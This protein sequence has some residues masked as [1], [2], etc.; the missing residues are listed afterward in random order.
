MARS[1]EN[2][3][4]MGKIVCG[5]VNRTN[6][7]VT[8]DI[9]LCPLALSPR[10]VRLGFGS[11]LGAGGNE[12]ELP[13]T[14]GLAAV[15]I[16][17]LS[18]FGASVAHAGTYPPPPDDLVILLPVDES[19]EAFYIAP[20]EAF[21]ITLCCFE[22]G[23]YVEFSIEAGTTGLGAQALVSSGPLLVAADG[24]VEWT[25]PGLPAGNYSLLVTVD[26]VTFSVPLPVGQIIPQA[27]S[28]PMSMLQP[29]AVLVAAGVVAMLVSYRRRP[30][31]VI[32]I[33]DSV[34]ASA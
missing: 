17:A 11:H 19:G 31:P 27:G 18:L 3:V 5:W 33:D 23:T 32:D 12:S 13:M 25:V 14:K 26:G 22:P 21:P 4:P 28:D 6:S 24:S 15:A 9:S 29:A 30:R 7:V 34:P 8:P 16:A 10:W 20:G 1:P 2:R